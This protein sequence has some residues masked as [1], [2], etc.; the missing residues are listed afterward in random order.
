MSDTALVVENLRQIGKGPMGKPNTIV[1][2]KEQNNKM[3]SNNI[4]LYLYR[5]VSCSATIGEAFIYSR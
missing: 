4:L 3:T 5:S 1:M 2:S